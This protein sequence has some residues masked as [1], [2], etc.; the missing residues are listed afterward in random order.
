VA[1]DGVVM[2]LYAAME[3]EKTRTNGARNVNNDDAADSGGVSRKVVCRLGE[4]STLSQEKAKSSVERGGGLGRSYMTKSVSRP[5]ASPCRACL[6]CLGR[7][8]ILR[9]GA[10]LRFGLGVRCYCWEPGC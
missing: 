6:G 7:G 5:W 8:G 10:A 1:A 4:F 3:E 9:H 2:V